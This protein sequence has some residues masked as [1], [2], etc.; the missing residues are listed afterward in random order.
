[1]LLVCLGN[2]FH[3]DE[4]GSTPLILEDKANLTLLSVC[5]HQISHIRMAFHKLEDEHLNQYEWRV[6]CWEDA[7]D[8]V[9]RDWRLITLPLVCVV[10]LQPFPLV[11]VRH[12]NSLEHNSIR[13]WK[14]SKYLLPLPISRRTLN[15]PSNS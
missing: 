9:S 4:E 14:V 10:V 6:Y 1:M 2:R 3:K 15:L 5:S 8:G 11:K 12:M 7:F 13:T